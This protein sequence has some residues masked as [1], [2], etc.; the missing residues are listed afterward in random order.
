MSL[1]AV[2]VVCENIESSIEFYGMLGLDFKASGEGHYEAVT[3]SGLSFNC[4]KFGI[5]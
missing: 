3:P 4:R 2:G 5:C 1:D